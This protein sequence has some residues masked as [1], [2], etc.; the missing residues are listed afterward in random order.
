[1]LAALTDIPAKENALERMPEFRRA[2]DLQPVSLSILLCL[3]DAAD[4]ED[5]YRAALWWTGLVRS[6][7]EPA[8]RSDLHLFLIAPAGTNDEPGWRARRSRIESDERFCRKF[9]WLPSRVPDGA[10][11][12]SFLNRTFLAQP[13]SGNSVEPRSLDP[14]EQLVNANVNSTLTPSEVRLWV[15][16]LASLDEIRIQ[17]IAEDLVGILEK[18]I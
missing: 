17:Q 6:E 12:G 9:L 4:P 5:S 1:V 16:R 7:M 13:W 8:R 10:E 15:T 18:K 11:I 14:L 3:L 2:Y